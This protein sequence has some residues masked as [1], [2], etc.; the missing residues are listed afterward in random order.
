MSAHKK[1]PIIY[2]TVFKYPYIKKVEPRI[3]FLARA[4]NSNNY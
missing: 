4:K 1:I 3:S 2:K